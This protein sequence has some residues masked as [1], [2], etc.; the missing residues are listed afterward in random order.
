M[1]LGKEGK[2]IGVGKEEVTL[3]LFADDMKILSYPLK[4]S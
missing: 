1:E 2:G 3:S 4:Y